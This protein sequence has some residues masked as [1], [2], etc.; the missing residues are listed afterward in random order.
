M[1]APHTLRATKDGANLLELTSFQA[2]AFRNEQFRTV[3]H[4]DVLFLVP[5][6]TSRPLTASTENTGSI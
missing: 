3:F 6:R 5:H 4:Q 1:W 2:N